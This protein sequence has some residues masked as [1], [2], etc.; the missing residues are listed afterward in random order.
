[1][2]GTERDLHIKLQYKDAYNKKKEWP[3]SVGFKVVFKL[4]QSLVQ[5]IARDRRGNLIL[6]KVPILDADA[7][8][9]LKERKNRVIITLRYD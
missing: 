2:L 8:T 3:E 5:P 7:L 6:P 1:M 4:F 9:I